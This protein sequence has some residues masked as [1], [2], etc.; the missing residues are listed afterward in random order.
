MSYLD[1]ITGTWLCCI[2]I[3]ELQSIIAVSFILLCQFML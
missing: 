1:W 3:G 2:S